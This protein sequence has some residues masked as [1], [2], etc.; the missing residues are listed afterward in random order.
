MIKAQLKFNFDLTFLLSLKEKQPVEEEESL[1]LERE[2]F[3]LEVGPK[4]SLSCGYI[5]LHKSHTSNIT[6][7]NFKPCLLAHR[8]IWGIFVKNKILKP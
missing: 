1:K 8:M 2:N 7:Q 4:L 5:T 6:K 3:G